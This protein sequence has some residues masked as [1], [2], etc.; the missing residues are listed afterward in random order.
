MVQKIWIGNFHNRK[1]FDVLGAQW[2]QLA[3]N[4]S[5]RFNNDSNLFSNN[6]NKIIRKVFG[7]MRVLNISNWN[8]SDEKLW[9]QETLTNFVFTKASWGISSL[10]ECVAF[11]VFVL[12]V[13]DFTFISFSLIKRDR[14]R[15]EGTLLLIATS[16]CFFPAMWT[17][18]SEETSSGLDRSS[19]CWLWHRR[20]SIP[21]CHHERSILRTTITASCRPYTSRCWS[22][23]RKT[24]SS[25]KSGVVK[26][27]NHTT[28]TG[29]SSVGRAPRLGRGGR[30]FEPFRPDNPWSPRVSSMGMTVVSVNEAHDGY[31]C[32]K[33][34]GKILQTWDLSGLSS[35]GRARVWKA[36]STSS[37]L[38]GHI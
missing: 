1:Y 2:R 25:K 10:P 14:N 12:S 13:V 17:S 16:L 35:V 7:Q 20:N 37:I 23:A 34:R 4:L 5:I 27:K 9:V 24:R 18:S 6:R 36:R 8:K 26:V 19:D 31:P 15:L 22:G 33:S 28:L 38:V 11:F 21:R 32:R 29:R 30:R 3:N